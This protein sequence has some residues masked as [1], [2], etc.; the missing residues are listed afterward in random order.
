MFKV[1]SNTLIIVNPTAGNGKGKL[2][3]EKYFKNKSSQALQVILTKFPG[4]ATEIAK[5]HSNHFNKVII[6]GGDG[7]VNEVFNGFDLNKNLKIGILPI[8]TGNDFAHNVGYKS[9]KI[10]FLIGKFLSE[11]KETIKFQIYQAEFTEETKDNLI[12]KR[13]FV[14]AIGIGFDALVA[15]IVNNKN[16][17]GGI[18]AYLNGVFNALKVFRYLEIEDSSFNFNFYREKF[19]ITLGNTKTSGGG[20]YLSPHANFTQKEIAVTII[21]KIGKSKIVRSLPLALFNLIHLVKEVTLFKSDEIFIKFKQ[22]TIFHC[23]GEVISE[24][25][26]TL[27]VKPLEH[28]LELII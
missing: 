14:N 24:K 1:S 23:D 9:S 3:Y 11:C 26:K 28:N 12:E 13:R 17:K 8:G 15:N 25:L 22:P 10:K 2:F 6:V 19:L 20:F 18:L 7:T 16:K 27:R 4:H 21:D 5:K